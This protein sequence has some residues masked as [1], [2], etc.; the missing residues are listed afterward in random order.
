MKFLNRK[1][2]VFLIKNIEQR[3]LRTIGNSS[4]KLQ[5]KKQLSAK[6]INWSLAVVKIMFASALS[7]I[8]KDWI[9]Q[10]LQETMV[11]SKIA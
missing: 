7:R 4:L 3:S 11:F 8:L 1:V 5:Y 9:I 10:R 6:A 2:L